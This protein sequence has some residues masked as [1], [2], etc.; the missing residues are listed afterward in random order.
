MVGQ[1]ESDALA[2]TRLVGLTTATVERAL[3]LATLDR[4]GG[5][6]T[7]AAAVL[8]L[9]V[10]TLRNKLAQYAADDAA[11]TNTGTPPTAA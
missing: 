3:I 9:S 7:H 1:D 6:R 8:G 2:V 4:L 10:R 5:N 11:S